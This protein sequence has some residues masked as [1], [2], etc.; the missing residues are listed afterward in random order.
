MTSNLLPEGWQSCIDEERWTTDA[1]ADVIS[2]TTCEALLRLALQ[3]AEEQGAEERE[4]LEFE[5]K[6]MKDELSAPSQA[7]GRWTPTM[8]ALRLRDSMRVEFLK[9]ETE[10][11]ALQ[12]TIERLREVERLAWAIHGP[13]K[14]PGVTVEELHRD[15]RECLQAGRQEESE[16]QVGAALDAHGK[17]SNDGD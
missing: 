1:G 11:D 4:R 13:E 17:G 14:P 7:R 10:R 2:A 16:G 6:H 5:N 8:A 12:A 15:M 9:V 3:H